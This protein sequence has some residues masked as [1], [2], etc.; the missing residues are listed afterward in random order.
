MA[1][2]QLVS[3][4]KPALIF[5]SSGTDTM[6]TSPNLIKCF[7]ASIIIRQEISLILI[8]ILLNSAKKIF[9]ACD[10][11]WRNQTLLYFDFFSHTQT[12]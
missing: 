1:R 4:L 12:R 2:L 5:I 6:P 3:K 9:S 11:G 10:V 7:L 8:F